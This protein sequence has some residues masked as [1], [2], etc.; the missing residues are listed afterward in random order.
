MPRLRDRPTPD[1][2]VIGLAV[3]LGFSIISWTVG[4]LV[5]RIVDPDAN[6]DKV[7]A[8]LADVVNTLIGAIF[9]FLAGRRTGDGDGNGD[10]EG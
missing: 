8:R 7:A 6:L 1:L 2:I 9:G 5:L 3:V 4:A 10:G